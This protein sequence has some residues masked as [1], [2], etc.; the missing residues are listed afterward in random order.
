MI[1]EL[2]LKL[3]AG[4]NE[5]TQWSCIMGNVGV[6]SMFGAWHLQDTKSQGILASFALVFVFS[7]NLSLQIPQFY[8]SIIG[9]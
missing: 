3:S 4:S 8:G 5:N 7:F 9:Y 2:S 1:S 6:C